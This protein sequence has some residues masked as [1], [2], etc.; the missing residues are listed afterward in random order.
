VFELIQ[1]MHIVGWEPTDPA[2]ATQ[3]EFAWSP[4]WREAE[5][6][7]ARLLEDDATASAIYSATLPP[8]TDGGLRHRRAP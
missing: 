5:R 1:Y 6:M 8:P 2:S 3:L 7:W 4:D